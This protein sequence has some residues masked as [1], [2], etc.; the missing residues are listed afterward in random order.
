MMFALANDFALACPCQ[1]R[2]FSE[3][4]HLHMLQACGYVTSVSFEPRK[5]TCCAEASSARM[6][7]FSASRL[8]LICAPSMR[9]CLHSQPHPA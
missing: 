1:P 8:L 6:H 5:G 3:V 9:V 7:S 2:R 4:F